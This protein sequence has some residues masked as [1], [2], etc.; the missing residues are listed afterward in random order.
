MDASLLHSATSLAALPDHEL[1]AALEN[2]LAQIRGATGAS[3]A[4]VF[5]LSGYREAG[6]LRYLSGEGVLA[7]ARNFLEADFSKRTA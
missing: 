3:S 6:A 4:T 5:E 7:Q 2:L 1:D